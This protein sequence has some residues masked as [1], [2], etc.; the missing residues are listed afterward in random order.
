MDDRMAELSASRLLKEAGY[1]TTF[2]TYPVQKG[3][4]RRRGSQYQFMFGKSG[5]ARA[6]SRSW[7]A[8]SRNQG[9]RQDLAET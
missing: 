8:Q 6:L 2:I 1:L 3:N 4:M 5:L 7:C 9:R